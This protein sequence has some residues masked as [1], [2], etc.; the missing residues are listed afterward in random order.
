VRRGLTILLT[1]ATLVVAGAGWSQDDGQ[2]GP[3]LSR[4]GADGCLGCHKD[5]ELQGVFASVHGE[6]GDARTPFAQLECESC[7]GPQGRHPIG[8][9]ESIITFGEGALTP[10][11]AQ[12]A[13]C[14]GCHENPVGNDWH[15]GEHAA[16][17]LSCAGCHISHMAKDPV[18]SSATQA[19]TC[20][21]CHQRQRSQVQKPYAHPVRFGRMDCSSCHAPHGSTTEG[22]LRRLTLNETCYECHAEKRGPFAFEHQPATEDCS[23]CHAPHGSNHPAMLTRRAPLLCQQCHS[24][25]GHPSLSLTSSGLPADSPSG[26]L[27]GGSCLNCH[28]QVH[29]SNHPSGI[30][31]M[32]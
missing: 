29:G 25:Q 22:S 27:L 7:H 3:V 5:P 14:L 31:Q 23:L 13:A 2:A 20:Y 21:Q 15:A 18:L 32:R 30:T 26:L 19:D 12:N 28:A 24:Q 16:Q 4:G 1:L 11:D 9:R 17:D 6:R 8:G 10:V